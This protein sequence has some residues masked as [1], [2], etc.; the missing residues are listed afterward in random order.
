MSLRAT[1]I[2][3]Q[4]V[5][6]VQIYSILKTTP[7]MS[8]VLVGVWGSVSTFAVL[9]IGFWFDKIGRRNAL[10][11]LEGPIDLVLCRLIILICYSSFPMQS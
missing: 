9:S 5:Y 1:G 10:V 4:A 8:L 6:Q 11:S 2:L 3:P 7:V